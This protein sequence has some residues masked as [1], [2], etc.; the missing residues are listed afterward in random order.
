[1]IE[2]SNRSIAKTNHFEPSIDL[3]RSTR[4]I[5]SIVRGKGIRNERGEK[6]GEGGDSHAKHKTHG[7]RDS[8]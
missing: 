3:I 2:P 5:Y 7:R 4:L 6:E 1:M 8:S